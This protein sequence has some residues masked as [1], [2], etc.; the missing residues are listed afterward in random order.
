VA[1]ELVRRHLTTAVVM[2]IG[3]ASVPA[4][5]ELMRAG[6][7][8]V[9]EKPL[10]A[11]RLSRVLRRASAWCEARRASQRSVTETQSSYAQLT[12][13]EREVLDMVIGGLTSRDIA[14]SLA[15]CERSVEIYRS[16][17]KK[18]MRTRNAADLVRLMQVLRGGSAPMCLP[19]ESK[20]RGV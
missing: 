4:V 15:L 17:I 7:F 3:Y 1:H 11:E 5:V 13:R 18:K 12:R 16:R 8:D 19:R 6:A 20:G 14:K 9:V 2:T 10:S